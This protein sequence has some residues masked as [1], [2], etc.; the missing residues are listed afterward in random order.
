MGPKTVLV[1]GAIGSSLRAQSGSQT[2]SVG[3]SGLRRRHPGGWNATCC[4]CVIGTGGV[5]TGSPIWCSWHHKRCDGSSATKG[6]VALI[7]VNMAP[8]RPN[9]ARSSG[10]SANTPA[11][12]CTLTSKNWRALH[13]VLDGMCVAVATPGEHTIKRR[14]GYRFIHTATDDRT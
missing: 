2:V 10:I 8:L 1:S 12:W 14:V 5:P 11:N 6:W 3:R 7:S 9:E 4:R 13:Q